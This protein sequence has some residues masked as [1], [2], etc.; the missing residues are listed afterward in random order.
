MVSLWG[1]G[2]SKFAVCVE[3]D[4]HGAPPPRLFQAPF[5]MPG[6]G[7]QLANRNDVIICSFAST[8][9]L[10]GEGGLTRPRNTRFEKCQEKVNAGEGYKGEDCVDEMLRPLPPTP[11]P[12]PLTLRVQHNALLRGLRRPQSSSPSCARLGSLLV[13]RGSRTKKTMRQMMST[14]IQ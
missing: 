10:G 11:R 7:N 2:H 1:E 9:R 6:L 13:P 4:A 12:A 3:P 14:H 8:C 5:S